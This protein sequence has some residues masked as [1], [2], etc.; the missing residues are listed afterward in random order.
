MPPDE[1][2][3]ALLLEMARQLVRQLERRPPP[4]LSPGQ[5]AILDVLT[6]DPQPSRRVARLA[7]RP[8]NSTFRQTLRG[9][10][11]AG[12]ARHTAVGYSR[13]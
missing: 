1:E 5:R 13:A 8:F 12:L 4:G 10:V 11:T 6:D 9:L 3:R 2:L 7:G